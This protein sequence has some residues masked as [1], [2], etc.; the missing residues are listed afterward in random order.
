MI[1]AQEQNCLNTSTVRVTLLALKKI[2]VDAQFLKK[3]TDKKLYFGKHNSITQ[4]Y[5]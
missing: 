4:P 2:N 5:C 1:K 3:E